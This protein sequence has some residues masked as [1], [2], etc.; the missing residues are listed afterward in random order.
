MKLRSITA[1]LSAFLCLVSSALAQGN[2]DPGPPD[3]LK[4][5]EQYVSFWTTEANWHSVLQLRNNS[6]ARDL[7]V[8]PSL[9]AVDGTETTLSPVTVKT[10]EVVSVNLHEAV[11]AAATRP[12]SSY[13]SVVLRYKAVATQ[14]LY[15]ALMVHRDARPI[16]FHIDAMGQLENDADYLREGVWWL[17]NDK[18]NDYLILT[19]QGDQ[20]MP[21]KLSLYD[22]SGKTYTK[23][24]SLSGR[25]VMRLS[26]RQLISEGNLGG[27]YG[28]IQ[29]H[30]LA[31]ARALDTLH[32]IYDED[33]GFSAL[34]KMFDH[35]PAANIFQRDFG[36]K[37][38]WTIHAPML[39][40]S[41]P[42][43]ALFIP[44][45][46]VLE[47]KIFLRNTTSQP[48]SA[49]MVFYWRSATK[50]GTSS[51][52][53]ISLKSHETREVNVADLPEDQA[54]P[55]D[56]YWASV[57][58]STSSKPDEIV[59]VAASYDAT[60]KYGAQTPFSD[61]LSYIWEGG[62]WL[63]DAS[64]NSLITVGNASLKPMKARF[65][66]FY[67]QGAEHYELEQPLEPNE[68]MWVDVGDLIRSGRPDINGKVLPKNLSSGSYQ[69]RDLTNPGVGSLFEGKV[70]YDLT[71]GHVTYGC[72]ACCSPRNIFMTF[73][74]FLVGIA[75][76][77]Y[78]SVSEQDGCGDPVENISG[79]FSGWGTANSSI[80]TTTTDGNHTGR[81][82][83]STTSNATGVVIHTNGR[84]GCFQENWPIS[85]PT[86]VY[87]V[88]VNSANLWNNNISVT[89]SSNTAASGLV[90]VNLVGA[91]STY[92]FQ[93]GTS[94]V[95]AGN[96]SISMN[97]PAIPADNYTSI[98][99]TWQ[100]APGETMPSGSL[101]I[102]W[103]VLGLIRHSQYNVPNESA[104]S[105]TTSGAWIINVAACS[106]TPITLRTAFT[107][108]VYINGTGTS[109]SNG[110]L[111]Y[112]PG[113]KNQCA[114]PQGSNDSN[115]F[116]HVS[117]I[118]GSCNVALDTT[119]VATNPNPT[120]SG[121]FGCGDNLSLIGSSNQQQAMKY[122][123]D[124][125]PACNS[126]F[127]GTSG[128]IDNFS[129]S[130]ACSGGAVGDYGNF[131]TADTYTTD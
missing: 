7:I 60:L 35:D 127:N 98:K 2:R 44:A 32:V 11:M 40:L 12:A 28:G 104:C 23:A 29:V 15:A 118:T 19:N 25:A 117:S 38:V 130:V 85:G 109:L 126:G 120:S 26:V 90:S 8:T 92:T 33:A 59:A 66:L 128:H 68:Q 82:V 116:A 61:Q 57:A 96:Y 49:S 46:T 37:G 110:I 81:A 72:A 14:V 75:A 65:T 89:L 27:S 39:A 88:T 17:P 13:G 87:A 114:Y 62:E 106:F 93:Y 115:T 50:T 30:A 22:A 99:V 10:H 84:N 105:A 124:Y 55:K 111:K 24:L 80:A 41:H 113:V 34:L 3:V 67:N 129:N 76:S 94:A 102:H 97:R 83:G 54:P 70:I 20:K 123:E 45:G 86:N 74:P 36:K 73:N 112:T 1:F 103:K 119:S 21:M 42:D 91:S 9:R 101:P 95:S 131:W 5:Q 53:T 100:I 107:N 78:D 6:P 108:Q 63:A 18:I 71:N 31:H 52:P 56:A 16:A 4:D 122:P 121:Y 69:F 47:P 77:V 79:A 48:E 64:H 58:I 125:C 51:G 43:P